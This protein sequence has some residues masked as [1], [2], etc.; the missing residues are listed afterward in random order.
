MANYTRKLLRMSGYSYALVLPKEL[1][2]RFGW[3]ERQKLDIIELDRKSIKIKDH[4][5]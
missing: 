5:A 2:K 3:K 4:R 1:V